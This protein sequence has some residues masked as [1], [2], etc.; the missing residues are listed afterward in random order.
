MMDRPWDLIQ[1]CKHWPFKPIECKTNMNE[2]KCP[3]TT[4]ER[5]Y[6]EVEILRHRVVSIEMMQR[7]HQ[8]EM[9]LWHTQNRLLTSLLDAEERKQKLI[10]YEIHDG[11]AQQLVGALQRFDAFRNQQPPDDSDAS[12]IFE[13]GTNLLRRALQ[14]A[15]RLISAMQSPLLEKF[16]LAM[17]VGELIIES[18][19]LAQV[20]IEYYN[21]LQTDVLPLSLIGAVYRIIQESLTNACY[22]SQSKKIRVELTEQDNSIR[23]LVQ[24]WGIGFDPENV[25]EG[26]FGLKGIQTRAELFGGEAV[27]TSSQGAGASVFV[28]IPIPEI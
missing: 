18:R 15:R 23:V 28:V 19:E 8:C 6:R 4:R 16:G 13:N 12:K 26:H 24:D 11:L 27:I 17:A 25:E 21:D 2:K 7:Q 10:A 3:K 5:L 20:E 22:H 14:D 9:E 1:D